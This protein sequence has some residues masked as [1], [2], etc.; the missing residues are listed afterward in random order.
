M[1]KIMMI[2]TA[3]GLCF[4]FCACAAKEN[5]GAAGAN[6]ASGQSEAGVRGTDRQG[7]GQ[8][9]S[10]QESSGGE[11]V[12]EQ[13]TEGLYFLYRGDDRTGCYTE[14]GYY[15][16][17]EETEEL[18]DGSYGAHLMYMDFATQQ[19][20]YLCSNTACNHDTPD[21][22]SVFLYEDF[23]SFSTRI[24]IYKDMLYILSKEYDTEGT[25]I[26]SLA[27]DSE[28]EIESSP[29]VLYRANL[30]GTD[31]E[32]VYAFDSDV[33]VEDLVLG[34]SSG[35]YLVTKKTETSKSGSSTYTT[36]T[37]RNLILVDVEKGTETKVCSLELNDD[38][39]WKVRG[40]FDNK[41]VL[42]GVDYGK[43]MSAGEIMDDDGWK[44]SYEN[45]SQVYALLAIDSGAYEEVY[46][47]SNKELNSAEIKGNMM[48]ISNSGTGEIRSVDLFTG[49]EKT[50]CS[51]PQNSIYGMIGDKLCCYDWSGNKDYTFYYVDVNTGEISHSSLVNK[52]L[53]WSLEFRAEL[54]DDV[55]VIYDYDYTPSDLQDDAY[56]INCYK[57]ALISKEDL[58]AGVANYRPIQ[59]IGKGK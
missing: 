4:S 26:T 10:G 37:D 5:G 7:V 25:V 49:E 55:L 23:P 36:S 18:S 56:E 58:Y 21:C 31:R 1:K 28:G 3:L 22:T 43:K 52:S 16:L 51:L 11:N 42:E 24:F 27:G 14:E 53:G 17:T 57:Y 13:G 32:K 35:I 15:Y 39:S 12:G 6:E 9:N 50:L 38:I 30:D 44:E 33:T 2:L 20:V 34:D 48:Y 47:V 54:V 59:M 46:R 19:E 40:C 45:S 8:G 41:L 29:A